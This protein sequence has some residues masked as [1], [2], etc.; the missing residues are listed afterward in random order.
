MEKD[1]K[2][3]NLNESLL[4]RENFNNMNNDKKSKSLGKFNNEEVKEI[5]D[6]K[7]TYNKKGLL[8]KTVFISPSHIF[9]QESNVIKCSEYTII[10]SPYYKNVKFFDNYADIVSPSLELTR[11]TFNNS[12]TDIVKSID[13]DKRVIEVNEDINEVEDNSKNDETLEISNN[14]FSRIQ[15]EDFEFLQLIGEGYYGKVHKVRFKKDNNIYALK[16]LKKSKLKEA[17]QKEHLKAE[18]NILS[19]IKHPFIVGLKLAFKTDKKLYLAMEYLKG[20]ELFFHMRKTKKLEENVAIFYIAQIVCALDFLHENK[21]IYRDL[22][23][24]NIVLNS[25]GYI[26]LTDFG[27]SKEGVDEDNKT[28]TFCG[29]PEYLS[30]EMIKGDQ[31][32]YSVDMW[33]LGVLYY[34]MLFGKPPFY[35]KNREVLYKMIYFNEP[36]YNIGNKSISENSINFLKKLLVKNPY[37]R[38][39]IREAKRHILFK[40]FN[41]EKLLAFEIEAPIIPID[42]V[43][44][45]FISIMMK[46]YMLIQN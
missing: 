30:P 3:N 36:N 34:E 43:R 35:D 7:F 31:Y 25:N 14:F 33:G 46:T 45:I 41:F 13:V 10:I 16:S 20:G 24:E 42:S 26:K 1:S 28:E 29:T 5:L 23:P 38:M 44:I 12:N 18:K 32:S 9:P 22:K 17:K 37:Q 39:N 6:K 40:T 15:P 27:L 21:I 19:N 4:S 8:L 2:F 11:I